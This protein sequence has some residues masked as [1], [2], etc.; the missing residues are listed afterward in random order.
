[1]FKFRKLF[2]NYFQTFLINFFERVM[3]NSGFIYTQMAKYRKI[4]IFKVMLLFQ[5]LNCVKLT[6]YSIE[7]VIRESQKNSFSKDVTSLIFQN[8]ELDEITEDNAIKIRKLCPNLKKLKLGHNNLKKLP[9]SIGI[10]ESLEELYLVNNKLTN[11]PDILKNLHKLKIL[12]LRNNKLTNLPDI[13]GDLKD[14]ENLWLGVNKLNHLPKSIWNAKKLRT[15]NLFNNSKL[16]FI[17]KAV[18]NLKGTIRHLNLKGCDIQLHNSDEN[19]G[20]GKIKL[21]NLFQEKVRFD[22]DR[23]NKHNDIITEE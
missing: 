4:M 22:S 9:E 11:I 16:M 1:M 13:F 14:L 17:P 21:R 12:D 19:D 8:R 15:L 6:Q 23:I 2:N 7:L 18:K 10:F 5:A 20:Y 3:A